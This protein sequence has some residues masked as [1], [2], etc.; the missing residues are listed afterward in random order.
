MT[1]KEFQSKLQ[2]SELA[3]KDMHYMI[4][5]AA[6]IDSDTVTEHTVKRVPNVGA[7]RAK[8]I[9]EMVDILS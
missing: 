2:D 4:R 1:G 9:M 6:W 3:W 7:T 5:A 8:K